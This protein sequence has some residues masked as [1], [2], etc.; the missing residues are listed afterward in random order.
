MS[1]R[2]P[3]PK[4]MGDEYYELRE[5]SRALTDLVDDL[6][7]DIEGGNY[8][9][10]PVNWRFL[11]ARVA[12]MRMICLRIEADRQS[13]WPRWAVAARDNAMSVIIGIYNPN[14]IIDTDTPP[15]IDLLDNIR[16]AYDDANWA[17]LTDL[18]YILRQKA[19][20]I[21][22]HLLQGPPPEKDAFE[23]LLE[24]IDMSGFPPPVQGD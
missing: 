2:K 15:K 5:C 19:Q 14:K 10:I 17:L 18:F 4:E 3:W 11:K 6:L 7:S 23:T 12:D 8:E 16:G 22:E 21:E 13:Y 9:A 20:R 24:T 1:P